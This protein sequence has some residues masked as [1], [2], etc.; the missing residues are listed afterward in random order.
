MYYDGQVVHDLETGRPVKLGGEGGTQ[1]YWGKGQRRTTHYIQSNEK[2]ESCRKF[3][4]LNDPTVT[5]NGKT[6]API[7]YHNT[8]SYTVALPNSVEEAV[9]LL[10]KGLITP[11]PV[12]HTHHWKCGNWK[13]NCKCGDKS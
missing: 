12:S 7:D 8:D 9:E 3:D 1:F 4:P 6:Y 13:S 10:R 5:I 11:A 2:K